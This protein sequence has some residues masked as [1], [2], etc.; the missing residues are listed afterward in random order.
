VRTRLFAMETNLYWT[1]WHRHVILTADSSTAGRKKASSACIDQSSL[2]VYAWSADTG[3]QFCPSI[4]KAKLFAVIQNMAI[5]LIKNT[6]V[7]YFNSEVSSD[8]SCGQERCFW[9][10]LVWFLTMYSQT[11]ILATGLCA[12]HIF[13]SG[14]VTGY[15][16]VALTP[17]LLMRTNVAD[18]LLIFL[19]KLS[20]CNSHWRRRGRRF[21]HRPRD[22]S[23]GSSS[24]LTFEPARVRPS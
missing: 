3:P 14:T 10:S 16:F 11:V 21:A 8:A 17:F 5:T 20:V 7:Y 15:L 2:A 4:P 12:P 22:P 19:L 6:S 23:R 9:S 13:S 24:P 1:Y 18:S